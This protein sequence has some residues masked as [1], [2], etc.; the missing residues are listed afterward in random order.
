MI[1]LILAGIIA[2]VFLWRF[3]WWFL[4]TYVKMWIGIVRLVYYL[5][6]LAFVLP[7]RAWKWFRGV[8]GRPPPPLAPKPRPRVPMPD[9]SV[10]D[11]N[12]V[13]PLKDDRPSRIRDYGDYRH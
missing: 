5:I 13:R 3:V 9:P 11:A 12:D 6:R 1:V 7:W 10:G 4:V 2:A 8:D